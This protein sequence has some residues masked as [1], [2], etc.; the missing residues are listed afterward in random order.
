MILIDFKMDRN[1]EKWNKNVW[2]KYQSFDKFEL[3]HS[4]HSTKSN[5]NQRYI[6]ERAREDERLTGRIFSTKFRKCASTRYHA[7]AQSSKE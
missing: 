5:F 3:D 7:T 4:I 6:D 1:P 2:L